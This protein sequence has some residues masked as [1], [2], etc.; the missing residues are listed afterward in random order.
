MSPATEKPLVYGTATC[1]YCMLARRLLNRK[2]VEFGDRRIDLDPRLREE[3]E[4]RS[5]GKSSVPQ[6]FIGERYIGGYADLAELDGEGELD[7][8]LGLPE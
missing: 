1:G 3:M 2:G 6:I 8:L 7:V 4:H 5:G